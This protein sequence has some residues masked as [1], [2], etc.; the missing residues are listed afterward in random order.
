MVYQPVCPPGTDT[1]DFASMGCQPCRVGQY[2]STPGSDCAPCP[3]GL[4][5]LRAGSISK[6]NC[7]VCDSSS[8]GHGRCRVTLPG[9]S[10]YCE[11]DFGYTKND[12]GRCSVATYYLAGTGLLTGILLLLLV[13]AVSVRLKRAQ[14][15]NRAALRGKDHELTEMTDVWT[16][17][18]KE[19][20]LGRRLDKQSPGGF[21]DVYK[22]DYRETTVAVKKLKQE[23]FELESSEVAFEREIQVMRTI[24]HPNV[25]MF[26]GVGHFSDTG[27]P[28]IVMEYMSRGALATILQRNSIAL[29]NSQQIRFAL[30]AAKGMRFLHSRRPP[31]IHRDLKS[32]NLLV[33]ERWVIKVADFG[34]ARLVEDEG[35]E[36]DAVKG[37]S[38]LTMDAPLLQPQY[39]L[40]TCVGT[41]LW[42]APELLRGDSYSA[43]VDVYR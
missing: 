19:L 35:V 4:S 1:Q 40:S 27:C 11:C 24:R 10:F 37:S 25:V 23:V 15:T 6:S 5:T 7:S 21:G 42:T 9:P 32:G 13:V 41:A 29:T 31:R 39:A 26:L 14:K 30:D 22:A 28:F 17:D 16:V 36:Q 43:A 3:E 8:C 2:S 33:S 20:R 34:S 18:P 12:E 38:R